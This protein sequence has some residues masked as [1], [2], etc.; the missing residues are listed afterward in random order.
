[1]M[2]FNRSLATL[3][4]QLHALKMCT[5][6][7]K[8]QF[9]QTLKL[10]HLLIRGDDIYIVDERLSWCNTFSST[11]PVKTSSYKKV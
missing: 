1:M 9:T 7:K 2:V 11:A 3:L 8:E 4:C 6:F 5:C 10:S